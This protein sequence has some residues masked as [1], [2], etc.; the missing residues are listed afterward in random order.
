MCVYINFSLNWS[1]ERTMLLRPLW[2]V[3]CLIYIV[4]VACLVYALPLL[5][6]LE[7]I[8]FQSNRIQQL[9]WKHSA[10]GAQSEDSFRAQKALD[11]LHFYELLVLVVAASRC[12]DG[13]ISR[14]RSDILLTIAISKGTSP[15]NSHFLFSSNVSIKQPNCGLTCF[16]SIKERDPADEQP[17]F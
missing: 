14:R 9:S 6:L 10:L 16:F 11:P 15:K 4:S 8:T 1:L 7:I 13:S 5:W 2:N 3:L 12:C 17:L